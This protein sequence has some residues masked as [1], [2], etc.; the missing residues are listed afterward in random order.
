MMK[1]AL[2]A[3]DELAKEGISAE[4]IDLRTIR[5]MDHETIINSV[6]KTNRI[7]VIDEAWPFAGVSAEITYNGA[8]A[9]PL[10]ELDRGLANIVGIVLSH[11]RFISGISAG[12]QLSRINREAKKYSE[13][14]TAF[15]TTI[16]DFGLVAQQLKQLERTSQQTVAASFKLQKQIL[17]AVVAY[18]N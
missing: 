17:K 8:L 13:L 10:G 18:I 7:I 15:G 5:P 16:K 9:Y 2:A 1:V 12:A 11:S 3:A 4:V 14:R 6:K